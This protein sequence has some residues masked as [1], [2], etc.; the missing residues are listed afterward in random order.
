MALWSHNENASYYPDRSII[1]FWL[2]LCY[3]LLKVG[4]LW[5]LSLTTVMPNVPEQRGQAPQHTEGV[6]KKRWA[7]A[8][9]GS[10]EKRAAGSCAIFWFFHQSCQVHGAGKM[11]NSVLKK[12][13]LESYNIYNIYFYRLK[14]GQILN[15]FS[16]ISKSTKL[17][18][19]KFGLF[20][21]LKRPN[22][23]TLFFS[24]WSEL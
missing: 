18:K 24:P 11:L 4:T 14:K 8:T 23:A 6:T 17:K 19:A 16:K 7:L 3:N 10:A 2:V 21:A 9:L 1:H 12:E 22:L 15:K 20:L 5:P 13:N